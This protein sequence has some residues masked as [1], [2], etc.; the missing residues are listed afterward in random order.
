MLKPGESEKGPEKR[1]RE[2]LPTLAAHVKVADRAGWHLRSYAMERTMTATQI[3]TPK[4]AAKDVEKDVSMHKQ[5][6]QG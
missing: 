4:T 5:K 1:T 3:V 2:A 6:A